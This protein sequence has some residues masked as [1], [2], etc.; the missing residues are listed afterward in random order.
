MTGEFKGV[1]IDLG[2]SR[3]SESLDSLFCLITEPQSNF[4]YHFW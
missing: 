2:N 4:T 3:K 1:L